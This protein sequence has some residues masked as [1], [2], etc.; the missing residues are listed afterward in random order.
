MQLKAILKL[1][2]FL[3][4]CMQYILITVYFRKQWK[5]RK[6]LGF[7]VDKKIASALQTLTRKIFLKFWKIARC[8]GLVQ[9]K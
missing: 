4:K 3:L 9:A 6:F 7:L 1:I 5:L 8:E 2:V